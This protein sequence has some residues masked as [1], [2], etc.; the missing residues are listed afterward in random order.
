MH[1]VYCYFMLHGACCTLSLVI[2]GFVATED[3]LGLDIY[4]DSLLGSQFILLYSSF[5][6]FAR[7]IT[8]R[9]RTKLQ[10]YIR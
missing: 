5:Y 7:G 8:Y 1:V 10:T 6:K 3:I 4:P 2:L 9:N